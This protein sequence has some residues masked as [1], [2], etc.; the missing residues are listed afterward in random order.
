MAD[1]SNFG[2]TKVTLAAPGVGILSTTPGDTYTVFDGTSMASPH[3]AGAIALYWGANPTLTHVQVINKL[4]ASVDRVP[5]LTGLV[6]TGGRLNVAKMF[7]VSAVPPVVVNAP[8]G[9]EVVRVLAPGGLTQLALTPHP[10]FTGGIV[11]ASG[12]VTGDG[13]SDVVTAAT[14][15]GHVKV[16]DGATAVE[17]RSFYGFPGYLGPINVAIGDLT[18]D[19]VGDII[20]AASANGHVKV[21]DGVTGQEAFSAFVYDGYFGPIAV[22]TAD[23]D[24]DGFNELL[25][26]ADGGL[27]VH[28]K[29]FAAGSLA[30]RDSFF[31]TGPG[32]WPEFSLSAIDLDLD[33]IPEV[34]VSQGPRVRV[35]NAQ[36]KA[37][38]ADFL[39]F[40]PLSMDRVTVQA[41]RYTGDASP[42]LV[43]VRETLG[44]AQVR[45]F[46]GPEFILADSFVAGTR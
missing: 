11:A 38:R 25:T 21:F 16:F 14:F 31:A 40:D 4:K 41:G 22:A 8:V 37:V 33:G 43:A 42:E 46:D 6:S 12:D 35:L 23:M 45:V 32:S 39:A 13:I 28:V 20:L 18:G 15:G 24:G 34:L 2:A 29:A 5:G 17:L 10:G 27:G 3:V 7:N 19:G 9:S 36:T 44:V 26:A 30:P 1:F